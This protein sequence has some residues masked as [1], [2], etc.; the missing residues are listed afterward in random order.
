MRLC[1]ECDDYAVDLA[2]VR[3]PAVLEIGGEK[4]QLAILHRGVDGGCQILIAIIAITSPLFERAVKAAA[5]IGGRIPGS[6]T[7]ASHL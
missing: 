7:T 6:P 2:L 5:T 3:Q 1:I 4:K